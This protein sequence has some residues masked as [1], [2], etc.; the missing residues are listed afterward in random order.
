MKS[1][2]SSIWRVAVA[3]VLIVSLGLVFAT[4]MT[5]GVNGDGDCCD[6]T[7][8][9]FCI[10]LCTPVN[11]Q[12]F[13][14]EGNAG[15]CDGCLMT[16]D[17]SEV[18]SGPGTYPWSVTC[19]N[20]AC[21]D[22]A[23]AF[24]CVESRV[25]VEIIEWPEWNVPIS[26]TFG[27]KAEITNKNECEV[28]VTATVI[29]NPLV[30]ER[31]SPSSDISLESMRPM[32]CRE[33]VTVAWTFHCIAEGDSQIAV[34]TNHTPQG[35]VSCLTTAIN[36]P[37]LNP[38]FT[39]AVSSCMPSL[40]VCCFDDYL[41]WKPFHQLVQPGLALTL[42]CPCEVLAGCGSKDW[43]DFTFDVDV[44]N[45]GDFDILGVELKA[46]VV[47]GSGSV[48]TATKTVGDIVASGSGATTTISGTC[49]GQSTLVVKVVATGI[50]SCTGQEVTVV[51][52]T[53]SIDQQTM[54]VD[55]IDI[56]GLETATADPDP[57]T[58]KTEVACCE[59]T[60]QGTD[61]SSVNA[62]F[63]TD[64]SAPFVAG[65]LVGSTVHNITDGSSGWVTA[66]TATTVTAT[67]S[68][69]TEND[70]DS[71][72]QYSVA[73]NYWWQLHDCAPYGL[74]TSCDDGSINPVRISG[75]PDG[76]Y[77]QY[78]A[79]TTRIWNGHPTERKDLLIQLVKP[80]G[81]ELANDYAWVN[82]PST[83]QQTSQ[84]FGETR[85]IQRPTGLYPSLFAPAA[86]S[87]LPGS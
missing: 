9:D 60:S 62:A 19:D 39:A 34:V 36:K 61:S 56:T 45:L 87:T 2:F 20:G 25:D 11:A 72:D 29:Y 73:C 49:L 68:G 50:D 23:E 80:C 41:D 71:G 47:S 33:E 27:I 6:A 48:D 84:P 4:P 64:G 3:L 44:D 69:G 37:T 63:L 67:L 86:M 38:D 7:A 16:L 1:K 75:D 78:F 59:N 14:N 74:T 32:G 22:T 15:C 10:P 13:I 21:T 52:E 51:E 54:R 24:V 26:T 46:S 31:V 35:A 58:M 81:T 42:D 55:V 57:P 85:L 17:F 5:A 28:P 12:L 79:I 83:T 40:G 66:N 65:G 8:E 30:V 77:G 70:W 53:C 76:E 18:E 82:C 43:N